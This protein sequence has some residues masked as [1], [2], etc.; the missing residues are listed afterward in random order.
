MSL[1]CA[2]Y[3]RY[4]SDRQSPE[5]IEDQL[6]KCREFAAKE[7]GE[8][9]AD[10]VYKD[11]EL[12]GAGADRPGWVKLLKAIAERPCPFDALLVDDTSRLSR[13]QAD[14]H[15]FKDEMR[16]LG[17]RFVAVSQGIDSKDEQSDVLMAVHGMVD[18][19]FIKL[20]NWRKRP[21]VVLKVVR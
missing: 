20:R 13:N 2:A 15:K 3:A 9:L 19:L 12:S 11:E 14:A 21:I 18:E 10:H 17:I 8:V 1:R 5:S 4:S 16:F 7:G 6:R